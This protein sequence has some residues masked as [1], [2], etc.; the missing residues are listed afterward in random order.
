MNLIMTI[1]LKVEKLKA[2][3]ILKLNYKSKNYLIK[4]NLIKL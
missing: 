3:I 1:Y 4:K 2:K